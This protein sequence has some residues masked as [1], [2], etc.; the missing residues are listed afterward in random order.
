[1]K[2]P[3]MVRKAITI[4]ASALAFAP[5]IYAGAL[6][7]DVIALFP[8]NAGEFAYADLH[9]A[10]QFPWFKQFQ[11]Q[12]LPERFRQFE[13]FLTTAG[14]N[15]NSQVEGLAWALVPVSM[16]SEN[17]ANAMPTSDQIVGIAQGQF[18]PN[19]AANYYK[20]Q[21]LST[22]EVQGFKL[23]GF[24]AGTDANDL[25]FMFIDTGTAAFGQR[26]LLERMIAVR[27]GTEESLLR[28]TTMADLIRQANGQGVFWGALSGAYTRLAINQ[29][30]PQ[31]TQFPQASDLIAK[32]NALLISVQGTG[33]I[34]ADFRALCATPQDA[35]T[36]SQLLQAGLLME[37][38]QAGQSNPELARMLDSAKIV[39]SSE[40]LDISFALTESQITSLI[41]HNTFATKMN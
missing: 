31:A 17:S 11:E 22:F 9:Q 18:D 13:Q 6:N 33:N 15:P 7:P 20:G 16:S 21:K 14:V 36:I 35:A 24:G 28:N 25:C 10:R 5:A 27:K 19:A 41:Q 37:R 3:D 34:E 26:N 12:V 4:A 40:R 30:L 29:L 38:Y 1:M 23:Y 39:P 32:V 2:F 8:K